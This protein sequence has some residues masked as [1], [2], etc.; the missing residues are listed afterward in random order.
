VSAVFPIL[1]L[2]VLRARLPAAVVFACVTGGML[3]F[4]A[5]ELGLP[6]G[7]D[8]FTGSGLLSSICV[9]IHYAALFAFGILLAAHRG[10]AGR[11]GGQHPLAFLAASTALMLVPSDTI[12]GIGSALLIAATIGSAPLSSALQWLPFRWL[13]RVSYSLYL[14]HMPVITAVNYGYRQPSSAAAAIAA[15]ALSAIA[16]ELMYRTIEA[17]S[18][19]LGRWLTRSGRVA[20]AA[21]A[22]CPLAPAS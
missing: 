13:G 11:L 4:R 17:P 19:R 7:Y 9:T 2:I 22:G 20:P 3:E 21:T 14:I 15:V 5:W 12:K 6:S 18:I 1:V 8:E 16:A 10:R